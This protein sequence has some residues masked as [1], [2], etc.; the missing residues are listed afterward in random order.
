MKPG[1]NKIREILESLDGVKRASAPDY[2]YTRLKARMEREHEAKAKRPW[3]LRPAYAIITLVLVLLV[4][5]AVILQKQD[6]PE[7]V[8]EETDLATSFAAEYSLNDN[9]ILY[10]LSNE[11]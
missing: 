11:Q 3:I 7:I 5:A 4:N 6:S 9:S 1:E 10:D 8:T 2:F